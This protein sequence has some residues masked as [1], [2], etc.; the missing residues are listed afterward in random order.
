MI[1][2]EVDESPEHEV[3]LVPG[4][5]VTKSAGMAAADLKPLT[6][7]FSIGTPVVHPFTDELAA[8]DKNLG[9][10][11][12]REHDHRFVLVHIACTFRPDHGAPFESASLQIQL[13]DTGGAD[14]I[15]WSMSPERVTD[16]VTSSRKVSIGSNLKILELGAEVETS[17]ERRDIHI[18]ASGLLQSDPAW[19]FTRTDRIA[20]RGSHRL[21]L[22]VRSSRGGTVTGSLELSMI[23]RQLRLGLIPYKV[24]LPDVATASFRY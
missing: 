12:V 10:F 7:L 6:G 20:I 13:Q 19:E 23:V 9:Q 18:E 2:I 5:A 16:N 11:L 22:V 24:E 4:P 1:E 14:A 17:A 3:R 15:A 21:F 8:Q